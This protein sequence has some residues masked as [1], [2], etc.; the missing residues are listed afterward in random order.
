MARVHHIELMW[1]HLLS[2]PWPIA[3]QMTR[4]AARNTSDIPHRVRHQRDQ[5]P[6]IVIHDARDVLFLPSRLFP[7]SIAGMG[8][9][10]DHFCAMLATFPSPPTVPSTA[11]HDLHHDS[12]ITIREQQA[13]IPLDDR[14]RWSALYHGENGT[15]KV[16]LLKHSTDLFLGEMSCPC[17]MFLLSW[18]GL[19]L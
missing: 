6:R 10:A 1:R 18:V 9:A 3:V 13:F 4:W 8:V 14:M 12:G 2:V 7:Q 15:T 5:T 19:V 16:P 11:N 17:L